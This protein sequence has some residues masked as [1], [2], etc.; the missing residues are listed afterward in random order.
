MNKTIKIGILSLA[1]GLSATSCSD[2]FVNREFYQDVE[3]APLTTTN[4]MRSFVRGIYSSMRATAY[5]GADFLAYAEIRS[6]EMYST[7]NG[8]YYTRVYNYNMLSDDG[9]ASATYNQIYTAVGKA[10]IV[11]NTDTNTITGSDIDRSTARYAQGQA[12]GLRAVAFFDAFR[13]YGQKYIPNGTLGV[14]LPLKFD[15]RAIQGRATISETE[16]QIEAD[17]AKAVQLMSTNTPYFS[18]SAKAEL[19][20][21]GLKGMMSRYYLYKGDYAKVRQ[22]TNEVLS[23]NKTVAS[24]DLH[25]VTFQFVMNGAAPNSIFELAVGLNSS[26][27]TGSY[28]QRLNRRGYDNI[29][30]NASA[31]NA[32]ANN[33]IRK[34]L[35][36]VT[37][38]KYYLS[39][40]EKPG[41]YTNAVGADN[42]KML[43][44]E[45]ILLNGVEAEI[46]G[47]SAAKALEY[48]KLL[49]VNRLTDIQGANGSVTT[50]ADQLKDITS[51]NMTM[52]KAE[53][54]KELLG[55][56][57]RQWDLR[58]WGDTVPRPAT[59]KKELEF[60]A[61]PIP[62]SETDIQNT[63]VK[64]NPGYDNYKG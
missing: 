56:G 28:R 13:L 26:L 1:L 22:L 17:F 12:Y 62:R 30:V 40:N 47:G 54:M 37:G 39:E 41:K 34:R 3:A 63:P 57:L 64:G 23:V 21:T 33:D 5:Y 18:E 42:I 35:I 44:V 7:T 48:Y 2:D 53:R 61:F 50:V 6:D 32:Y 16:A 52:L 25:Q 58:R 24:P 27:S 45:E 49:L 15:P 9:Y 4:E 29:L 55:E 31:Y 43:R 10:N 8:G 20:V 51:V 36:Y 59:A 38:G 11:I 14:V 19:S 60:N 46:N